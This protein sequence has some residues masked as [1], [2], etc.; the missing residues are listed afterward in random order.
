[1][2]HGAVACCRER[3][4]K[5]IENE[6]ELKLGHLRKLKETEARAK[7]AWEEIEFAQG[8]ASAERAQ[9]NAARADD[10]VYRARIK[11]EANMREHDDEITRLRNLLAEL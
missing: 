4:E 2:Y 8:A 5:N 3:L 11:A 10:A 9:R 6:R 1:M 7:H